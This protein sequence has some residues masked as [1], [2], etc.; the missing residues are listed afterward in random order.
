VKE[1]GKVRPT[2]YPVRETKLQNF[3]FIGLCAAEA[4][5]RAV[6]P[7]VAITDGCVYTKKKGC[8]KRRK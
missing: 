8:I 7:K 4:A 5:F 1:T 6:Q 2:D 3:A